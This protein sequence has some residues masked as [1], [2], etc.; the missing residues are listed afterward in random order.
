LA[1]NGQTVYTI[2]VN[3][4]SLDLR[5]VFGEINNLNVDDNAYAPDI[6]DNDE[7]AKQAYFGDSEGRE[8]QASI[9]DKEGVA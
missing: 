9:R 7:D 1:K 4:G 6:D 8:K 2:C 5:A 3:I